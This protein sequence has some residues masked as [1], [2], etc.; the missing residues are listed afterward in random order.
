MEFLIMTLAAIYWFVYKGKILFS[1]LFC[2]L[3]VAYY[4]MKKIPTVSKFITYKSVINSTLVG[5]LFGVCVCSFVNLFGISFDIH[6]VKSL[7]H[8]GAFAITV[9]GLYPI[10]YLY[11]VERIKNGAKWWIVDMFYSLIIFFAASGV[12][13]TVYTFAVKHFSGIW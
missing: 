1:V 13:I 12:Y 11:W 6:P 7:V 9:C 8:G 4:F 3:P 10:T 5:A 2:I